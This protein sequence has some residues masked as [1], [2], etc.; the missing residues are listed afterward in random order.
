MGEGGFGER[1]L[2]ASIENGQEGVLQLFS[3]YNSVMTHPVISIFGRGA[4][5]AVDVDV[6]APIEERICDI[7]RVRNARAIEILDPKLR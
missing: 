2:E 4:V 3:Q 7:L 5:L 6:T 1:I